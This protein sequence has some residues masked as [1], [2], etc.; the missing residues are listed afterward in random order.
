VSPRLPLV[1]RYV[2]VRLSCPVE[3]VGS[4]TGRTKVAARNH[5]SGSHAASTLVLG[6]AR[7]S[8]AP[9]RKATVKVHVSRSTRRHLARVPRLRALVTNAARSGAGQSATS[10]A[11]VTIRRAT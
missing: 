8:I 4:C 11:S 7:F 9:G 3:T 6:R 1:G 2:T 5:E 10:I